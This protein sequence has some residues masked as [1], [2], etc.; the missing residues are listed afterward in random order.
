MSVSRKILVGVTYAV[1]V[2]VV[3]SVFNLLN[4][5]HPA[6][7]AKPE[8]DKLKIFSQVLSYVKNNYVEEVDEDKLIEGAI[9]GM[10]SEIDAHSAW[11]TPKQYKEM[12]SETKGEFGGI[13]IEITMKDRIL[14]IVSPIEDTPAYK[15]GLAAGDIIV[16][17]EGKMTTEMDIFEAVKLMRGKPQSK[18]TVTIMRSD[19]KEP[20]DFVI[21]RDIIRVKSVKYQTLEKGY[22]YIKIT[23]FQEK[24]ARQLLSALYQIKKEN[25]SLK[26]LILD[27]RNNPGGLLPQ[28]LQVSDIF[29]EEG[30]I[31]STVG[32]DP[33]QKEIHYAHKEG[34]FVDF[35]MAVLI[36]SGSAS[37]SE[38]VAGALQD[39]GRAII[40][41]EK[42]FGKGSVQQIIAMDDGSALKLTVARF[43]TP[44]DRFIQ[45]Y[46]ITPDAV[47]DNI[48]MENY[49]K[50]I[51]KGPIWREKD[52]DRHLPGVEEQEDG[53]APKI[54]P[55]STKPEEKKNTLVESDYQIFQAL[56]YLKFGEYLSKNSALQHVKIN[57]APKKEEGK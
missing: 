42:S 1:S 22:G 47:L 39:S 25:Q 56:N 6:H 51:K 43:A 15:S 2:I 4:I 21:M 30:R 41:G 18:V 26:G 32:R 27:L 11:L 54:Q 53:D 23:Q 8:S 7:S 28:A 24:T 50:S 13:G 31:V 35:P 12:M 44:K 55:T 9:R 29:L 20:K 45:E 37:A 46:G 38:I 36:N 52:Y 34:S 33:S 14:T 57:Q 5:T 19:F 17:I 40:M 3:A 16:K 48:D 49:Q 10:L